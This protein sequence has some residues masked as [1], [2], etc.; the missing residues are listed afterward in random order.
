[1]AG[2][3]SGWLAWYNRVDDTLKTTSEKPWEIYEG[4]K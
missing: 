3:N 2:E 4:I 1:M